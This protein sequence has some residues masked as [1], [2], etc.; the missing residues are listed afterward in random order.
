MTTES[1]AEKAGHIS[2]EAGD[3]T[4]GFRFQKLRAAIRFLQRVQENKDGQV[5]CA[6]EFMEDSVLFDGSDTS[7]VSGEENKYYSSG[8]SFNSAAVKN[9]LVAFLDLYFSFGRSKDLKLGV[10]ASATVA[11]ERISA[12]FRSELGFEPKQKFY[13]ILKKLTHQEELEDEDKAVAFALAKAVYFGEYADASKGYRT[14]LESMAEAEFINF[15]TSIDW[16]V[17]SDSNDSLETAALQLIR[18]CRFY[19]HRHSD[20]ENFILSNLMDEIEK[21]AC[22]K[23]PLDRLVNTDTLRSIFNE[24]IFKSVLSD[25]VEDPAVDEWDDIN[26]T[27]FRNLPDKILAVCPNFNPRLLK[28]LAK[29]CSLSRKVEAEGAREMKA[30]LRRILDVCE[31]PLIQKCATATSFTEQEVT[32]IIDD[33]TLIAKNHITSLSSRYR[34]APRDSHAVKGAVLTLF[35]DCFLAFD[36]GMNDAG[37]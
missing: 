34:Y 2:R 21:R 19:N 10:Y 25:Q 9:T 5:L 28:V 26:N 7:P 17:A 22:S 1:C 32:N 6:M 36:E 30:L 35:D 24:I 18:T 14:L 13:D 4:K 12:E 3:K 16:V 23:S 20:L 37:Q 33:L 31:M 11:Q 8:L 15:L 29:N 27:D